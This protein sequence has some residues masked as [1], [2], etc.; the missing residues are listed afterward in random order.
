MRRS[1]EGQPVERIAARDEGGELVLAELRQELAHRALRRGDPGVAR[2]GDEAARHE[3]ERAVVELAQQRRLPAVPGP[4][5]DR[6][7]VGDGEDEEQ[8]QPLGRLYL[9]DE[10]LDGLRVVDV[11]P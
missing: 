7:D 10:I 2:L 8:L 5:P 11:A 6:A 1:V 3:V 4:G 9:A